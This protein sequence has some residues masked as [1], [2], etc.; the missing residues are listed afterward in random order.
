MKTTMGLAPT[1]MAL[2]RVQNRDCPSRRSKWRR[3]VVGTRIVLAADRN[4][5]ESSVIKTTT[6]LADNQNCAESFSITAM[7]YSFP[8]PGGP[9]NFK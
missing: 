4:G 1:K 5:A 7:D 9:V 8:P 2:N 6:A 3:L